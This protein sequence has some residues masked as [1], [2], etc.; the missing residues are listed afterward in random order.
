MEKPIKE[1][2]LQMQHY[3]FGMKI[4]KKS[5]FMLYPASSSSIARLEQFDAKEGSTFLDKYN[6]KKMERIICL[7]NCIS[8][9][10]IEVENTPKDMSAFYINT[11]EK[12]WI[13]AAPK[14]GV[15]QWITCLCEQ[16]FVDTNAQNKSADFPASSSMSSGDSFSMKDN[17]LYSSISQV[18]PDNQF[19]VTVQKT[20][21]T[22][23]C[24]L[25]GKYTLIVGNDSL[26]LS[27]PVTKEV[28]YKWPYQLLRR[29][30]K[31]QAVFTFE[32]GRRCDSGEGVFQFNT[33]EVEKIYHIVGRFVKELESNKECRP[34]KPIS[35]TSKRPGRRA[36][37]APNVPQELFNKK[38]ESGHALKNEQNPEKSSKTAKSKLNQDGKDYKSACGA[39][40]SVGSIGNT[41]STKEREE[42]PIIYATV[43]LSKERSKKEDTKK[44]T[45]DPTK[46]RECGDGDDP[47]ASS[48]YE[49]ISEREFPYSL[50]ERSSFLKGIERPIYQSSGENIKDRDTFSDTDYVNLAPEWSQQDSEDDY[51]YTQVDQKHELYAAII[52]NKN[53]AGEF[54]KSPETSKV[55]KLPPGFHEMLSDLYAK[56]PSNTRECKVERSSKTQQCRGKGR[57]DS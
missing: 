15:M 27:D 18:K 10:R 41:P 5:L 3:K 39:E 4:W 29:Y 24:N 6:S 21:T 12:N 22:T 45:P 19:T 35:E 31:D 2:I 32:A 43:L 44:F 51:E 46:Y 20:A 26:I 50:K 36:S 53:E 54:S 42:D 17:E 49:N 57:Y 8:I 1:G 52:E 16:A 33:K 37:N 13:L 47:E 55:T 7:S 48:F 9:N 28:V 14:H 25:T 34:L 11:M 30:G 40:P 38:A 56:P 23:R